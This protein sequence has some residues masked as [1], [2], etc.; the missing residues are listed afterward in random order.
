MPS[1]MFLDLSSP[2]YPPT[3]PAPVFTP[4]AAFA[5]TGPPSRHANGQALRPVAE[6]PPPPPRRRAGAVA[7][8]TR[9][10]CSSPSSKPGP[11]SSVWPQHAR[12]MSDQGSSESAARFRW[13]LVPLSFHSM[14]GCPVWPQHTREMSDGGSVSALDGTRISAALDSHPC[15]YARCAH[16]QPGQRAAS[17]SKQWHGGG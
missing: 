12:E 13:L 3:P 15:R 7:A 2:N 16:I 4:R 8:F 6:P 14:P 17:K 11:G 10:S 9:A 1:S 5:L